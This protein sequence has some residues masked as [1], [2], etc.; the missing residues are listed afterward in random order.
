MMVE[1][2]NIFAI[3]ERKLIYDDFE[4]SITNEMKTKSYHQ[5]LVVTTS[6]HNISFAVVVFQCAFH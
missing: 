1:A 3:V 4:K 6:T 2:S 5:I